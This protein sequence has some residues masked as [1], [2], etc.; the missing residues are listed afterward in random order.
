VFHISHFGGFQL[1]WPLFE[2]KTVFIVSIIVMDI[3]HYL[4]EEVLFPQRNPLELAHIEHFM[5]ITDPGG[6]QGADELPGGHAQLIA[7]HAVPRPDRACPGK[8]LH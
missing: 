4:G 7:H 5:A 3:G 8:V 1:D 2:Q 6:C